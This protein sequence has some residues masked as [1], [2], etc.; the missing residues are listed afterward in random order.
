MEEEGAFSVRHSFRTGW[1]SGLWWW[2]W[3]RN[4]SSS[5]NRKCQEIARFSCDIICWKNRKLSVW[6]LDDLS[7]SSRILRLQSSSLSEAHKDRGTP[8]QTVLLSPINMHL[9]SGLSSHSQNSALSTHHPLRKNFWCLP[10]AKVEYKLLRP[11]LRPSVSHPACMARPFSC[12]YSLQSPL[13]SS[14]PDLVTVSCLPPCPPT[15]ISLIL[16]DPTPIF[17][18]SQAFPTSPA[19]GLQCPY[20]PTYLWLTGQQPYIFSSVPAACL[21]HQPGRDFSV[22]IFIIFHWLYCQLIYAL[23]MSTNVWYLINAR[24][25]DWLHSAWHDAQ[26]ERNWR[27]WMEVLLVVYNPLDRQGVK[28]AENSRGRTTQRKLQV[29]TSNGPKKCNASSFLISYKRWLYMT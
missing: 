18:V 9:V 6:L 20:K 8:P 19:K 15:Q 14:S 13:G 5:R 10:I 17:P 29:N 28:P 4:V 2:R 21:P 27:E 11:H 7:I 25:M 12:W 1:L 3:R 24:G 23:Y 22:M 26:L 16:Q